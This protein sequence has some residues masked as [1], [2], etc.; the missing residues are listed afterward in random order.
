MYIRPARLAAMAMALTSLP[1]DP[2]D[3]RQYCRQ[4]LT[5]LQEQHQLVAKL[6]HEF[7]LFRRYLYGRR[8]EKLDPGQ[9]LLEFAS[10][11]KAMNEATPA[12]GSTDSAAPSTPR[13]RPGHGRQ[14]L[15]ALLPR[16]RVKHVLPEEQCTCRECGMITDGEPTAHMENGEAEFS[17]P[18][19]MRTLQETL[20]EVQ[21]CTRERITINTFMLE[22]SRTLTAFVEQM[23]RINRGRAF[24]ATP[25][26][27]GE[28]VLVDFVRAAGRGSERRGRPAATP[29]P[30][31][32]RRPVKTSSAR[33]RSPVSPAS[34]TSCVSACLNVY[35]GSGIRRAS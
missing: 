30:Q 15:P 4:L 1:Q 25:D 19:T 2:D 20:K 9:L 12:D 33:R 14:P 31:A 18:P 23:A 8:S 13:P 6:T 22:Q 11:V 5:E 26:R 28:Y 32:A 7:A 17:Y 27:L 24:F 34:A 16:Q 29:D 21:R 10:W 35:S 3:L